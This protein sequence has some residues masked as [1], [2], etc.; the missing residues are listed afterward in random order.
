MFAEGGTTNG[1]SII[2]LKKGGFVSEVSVKPVVIKYHY[3]TLSPAYDS[4]AFFPLC[5]FQMSLFYSC[6]SEVLKLPVFKP[7][8]YLFKIH[9]DKG[10]ERWEIYAWAVR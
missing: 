6:H 3:N 2:P 9:A 8:E 4:L 5:I 7:N 10:K 1:T